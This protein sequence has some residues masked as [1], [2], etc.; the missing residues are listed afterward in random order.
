[1]AEI[2]VRSVG[3]CMIS[4][5]CRKAL[6][7]FSAIA[8]PPRKPCLNALWSIEIIEDRRSIS[9]ACEL[10]FLQGFCDHLLFSC[11]ILH[12]IVLTKRTFSFLQA[13]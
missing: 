4:I 9:L 2:T 12:G 3:F 8:Q 11:V 7:A 13:P 1:M 10:T 6:T 5:A